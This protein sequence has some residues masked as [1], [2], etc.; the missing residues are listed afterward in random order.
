MVAGVHATRHVPD[1]LVSRRMVFMLT[2]PIPASG[3]CSVTGSRAGV[4]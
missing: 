4:P 2:V 3:I 1:A